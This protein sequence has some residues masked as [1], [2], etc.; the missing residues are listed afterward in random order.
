M[1]PFKGKN[2]I[3]QNPSKLQKLCYKTLVLAGSD[4]IPNNFE[5]YIEKAV[6]PPEL[7]D[8]GANWNVVLCI[9]KSIPLVYRSTNDDCVVSARHP[10]SG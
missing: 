5:I 3:K 4:G 10:L 7:P 2:R 1:V 6:H 9:A 8:V